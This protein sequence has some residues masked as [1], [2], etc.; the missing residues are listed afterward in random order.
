MPTWQF[1][2]PPPVLTYGRWWF[3]IVGKERKSFGPFSSQADA[4]SG[5]Q[6]LFRRWA[7][8]ACGLGGE[9]VRLQDDTWLVTLPEGAPCEGRPFTPR[10]VASHRG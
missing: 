1:D 2:A 10:P 4:E 7:A 5:R 9:A 6:A 3:V 8:R